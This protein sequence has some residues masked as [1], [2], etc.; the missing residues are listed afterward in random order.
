MLR[1]AALLLWLRGLWLDLSG[2]AFLMVSVESSI[3]IPE[4]SSGT[5]HQQITKHVVEKGQNHDRHFKDGE[6]ETQSPTVSEKVTLQAAG[7]SADSPTVP[8]SSPV[9]QPPYSH[10]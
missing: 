6:A 8:R 5:F 4:L 2:T 9:L 10:H 3:S 1:R 7:K